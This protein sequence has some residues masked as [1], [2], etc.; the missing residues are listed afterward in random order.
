M[1]PRH[2][3]A[4]MRRRMLRL[5]GQEESNEEIVREM[6]IAWVVGCMFDANEA[7]SALFSKITQ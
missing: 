7:N 5:D 6:S 1:D 2:F 3:P 4:P